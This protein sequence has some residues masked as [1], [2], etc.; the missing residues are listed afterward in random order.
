MKKCTRCGQ[1]KSLDE[2]NRDSS[3]SDGRRGMCKVCWNIKK[4]VHN[5]KQNNKIR[6]KACVSCG[7]WYNSKGWHNGTCQACKDK[8][9]YHGQCSRVYITQCPICSKWLSP[10]KKPRINNT[11]STICSDKYR[12]Y[13]NEE[14][15]EY[16]R[17][18]RRTEKYKVKSRIAHNKR[19]QRPDVKA[20]ASE[21]R[22]MR[23]AAIQITDGHARVWEEE[24]RRQKTFRCYLCGKRFPISKLTVDHIIDIKHGG[25]HTIDNLAAACVSCNSRKNSKGI[26][27]FNQYTEGQMLLEL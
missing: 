15:R 7:D 12:W 17:N 10:N 16:L 13:N 25:T 3:K 19:N 2:Y 11:C 9:K 22:H 5:K 14:R 27:G 6:R 21:Y 18:I 1:I 4:R 24:I 20:K 26:K 23:R 8:K